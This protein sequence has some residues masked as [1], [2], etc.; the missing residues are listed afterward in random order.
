MAKKFNLD[1]FKK[2][3]GT[4][5]I[6]YKPDQHVVVNECL[7][8][9]IG[10]PGIPLGHITQCYGA[11]DTGKTS[12]LFHVAAQAQQQNIL[13]ILIITEKKVDW[14]RAKAMGFDKDGFGIVNDSCQYIEE[15]F[16]FMDNILTR[17]ANGELEGTNGCIILWDSVGNTLSK[18]EVTINKDGSTERKKTM[19]VAARAISQ[20]M[21]T[22]SDKLNNTRQP[23]Y[24][25]TVGAMFLNHAYTQPA[26]MPGMPPQQ[27]PYG[28]TKIW[29][30]SSLVL[31]TS[32]V[33][34]LT[35]VVEGNRVDF[36]MVSKIA[37][38]K[39][40]LTSI[41]NNGQF[42]IVADKIF[43]NDKDA[44]ADY[45]EENREKWGNSELV[46]EEGESLE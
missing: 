44:I 10:M 34:R 5:P 24:P 15:V 43:P 30:G 3:V 18:E 41:A 12:L 16:D 7:Q 11:S 23:K 13:P 22:F 20:G 31:Q 27:V 8:Q 25:T 37:V 33:S 45:K 14:S 4:E 40:H 21:R 2:S 6:S 28:G 26:T 29:Y 38:K 42:V 46:A 39:N 35:A 36:G 19:M 32:K 17:A 1:A 9:V